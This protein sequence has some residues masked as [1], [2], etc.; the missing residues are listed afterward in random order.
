VRPEEREH[1]RIEL[2]VERDAV[3]ARG[4]RADLGHGLRQ[5]GRTENQEGEMPRVWHDMI[6]VRRRQVPVDSGNLP[7]RY[8][9]AAKFRCPELHRHRDRAEAVASKENSKRVG[10][11]SGLDP[12][13]VCERLGRKLLSEDLLAPPQ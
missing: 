1:I 9:V 7:I 3:K 6:F 10:N 5:G 2:L 4:I 11:D 12:R 13:I 8:T